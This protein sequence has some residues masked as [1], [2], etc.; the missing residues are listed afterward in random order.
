MIRSDHLNDPLTGSNTVINQM[1]VA[2]QHFLTQEQAEKLKAK[3][4]ITNYRIIDENV[5]IAPYYPFRI[6]KCFK[7]LGKESQKS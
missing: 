7:G 5:G 3:P 6:D 4:L 2:H 1:A